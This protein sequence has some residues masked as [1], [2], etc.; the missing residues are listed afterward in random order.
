MKT[1]TIP[2]VRV[3]P[4]RREQVEALLVEGETV[5]QFVEAS[6]RATVL[7]RRHRAEFVARGMRSLEEAR[8]S[9]RYVDAG[10]ALG[11]LQ[12]KWDKALKKRAS[13]GPRAAW[14]CSRSLARPM[15]GSQPCGTRSKTITTD[16][17]AG[18]A[19]ATSIPDQPT[20]RDRCKRAR[21][22]R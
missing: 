3:E 15:W 5:S 2:S 18:R 8:R 20:A 19:A 12:Q 17:R 13:R 22:R 10:A 11:V 9:G 16:G 4:E 6:V 1:T 7:R 21:L 14:C